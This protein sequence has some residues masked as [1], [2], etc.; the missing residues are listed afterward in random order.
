MAA[1]VCPH[2]VV[3]S[4]EVVKGVGSKEV[5]EQTVQSGPSLWMSKLAR[6]K[7]SLEG[8]G[9]SEECGSVIRK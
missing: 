3:T 1:E 5:K 8:R 6:M 2:S 9:K 4:R 7:V